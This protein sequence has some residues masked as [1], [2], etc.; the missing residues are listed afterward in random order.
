[1]GVDRKRRWIAKR[2]SMLG[3]SDQQ[4]SDGR[5]EPILCL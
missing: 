3:E 1:M 2:L 4:Q 5:T